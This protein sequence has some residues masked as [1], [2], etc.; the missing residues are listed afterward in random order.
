M[1]KNLVFFGVFTLI[2]LSILSCRKYE[3]GPNISFRSKEARLTNSWGIESVTIN[4]VE[5]AQDPYYAK[6]KHYLYPDGSYR[7]TVIDPN[8]LIAEN[9][10]GS[11]VMYDRG[12]KLAITRN[13]YQGIADSVND[14]KIL[15]LFEKQ[16]WLRSLD[17][18]VEY[19]FVP[20]DEKN[21]D[22]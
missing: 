20:Y 4:G 12:T 13:N 22:K 9:I 5:N 16:L 2:A 18:T 3:E 21:K 10:Q 17:N 1:K 14:Y 8:T 7:L 6:Q 19:H 15:K 11:W